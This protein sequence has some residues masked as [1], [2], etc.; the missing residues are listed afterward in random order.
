MPLFV[1]SFVLSVLMIIIE[2]IEIWNWF[3]FSITMRKFIIE[4]L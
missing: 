2:K 4:D 1:L 3:I